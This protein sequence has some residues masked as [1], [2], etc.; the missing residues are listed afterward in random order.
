MDFQ[1]TQLKIYPGRWRGTADFPRWAHLD[2]SRTRDSSAIAIG[3]CPGFAEVQRSDCVVE[4]M[5]IIRFDLLLEVR[6]PPG[7]EIR[8]KKIR[9][10][11]YLLREQYMP[12]KWVTADQYQS[13]D[14]LQTLQSKG[15]I[16]SEQSVDRTSAPYEVARAALCEGRAIA[17]FHKKAL[18]EWTRLELD[19]RTGKADHAPGGSKD[20]ADAMAGVIYGLTMETEVWTQFNIPLREVPDRVWAAAE[21][22]GRDR[23]GPD[24][25]WE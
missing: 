14:M 24:D 13:F 5:P 17:P 15:F 8:F 16:V 18:Q 7:G 25:E 11:L 20:L 21:Q 22:G 1:T 23:R 4:R 12:I 3:H 9:R 19:P 6:P 10:L 2:L